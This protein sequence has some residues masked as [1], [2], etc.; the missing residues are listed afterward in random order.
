MSQLVRV[1]ADVASFGVDEAFA[2]ICNFPK[3]ALLSDAVRS[4]T[5]EELPDGT[6][7]S[8][9]R[10]AFRRGTL[11]WSEFDEFD[12]ESHTLRFRVRDGDPEKFDGAWTVREAPSGEG[13]V[14]TFEAEFDVGIPTL[15]KMLEPIA[16]RALQDN[17][18]QTIRGVYGATIE[19]SVSCRE[20]TDAG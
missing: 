6:P 13:C 20:T 16:V 8:H 11:V 9:W 7:I 18:S 12:Y 2:E 19:P 10:V 3:H 17:I 4:V 1:E 15:R 14:I 5:V